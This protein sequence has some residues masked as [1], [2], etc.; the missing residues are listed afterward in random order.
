VLDIAP[1]TRHLRGIAD[2]STD[3]FGAL[4]DLAAVMKRHPLAWRN[5]LEG[6]AVACLFEQPSTRSRVALEV[7]VSRLGALPVVLAPREL[8]H[9]D[10]LAETADVLSSYCDAVAVRTPHHRD[11]L[12]LAEHASVPVLNLRTDREDPF[13]ALADCLSLRERFGDLR[14]L[15]VAFVGGGEAVAYSLIEAAMLVGLEVRVATLRPDPAL[16]ARA[17][18]TVRVCA[19]SEEAIDGAAFVYDDAVSHSADLLPV[20]QAVLRALVTGD[21][22]L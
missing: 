5:A 16:L 10:S 19:S 9:G 2:L 21:L 15:P 17:G 1:A 14:G 22:E 20:Q 13:R 3:D 11:L 12:E 8:A 4:L 18:E 6:R 7:A